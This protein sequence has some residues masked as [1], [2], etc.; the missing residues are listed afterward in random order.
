MQVR[1]LSEGIE[2]GR[3]RRKMKRFSRKDIV[4]P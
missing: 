3:W 2:S 1:G 4:F